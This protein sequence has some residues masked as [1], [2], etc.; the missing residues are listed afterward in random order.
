MG[1]KVFWQ[2]N[3]AVAMGAIDAGARFFSGYPITP[4]SEIAEV[5]SVEL[6]KVG[7]KFMQM[8]DEIA[9]IA[10]AIGASVGGLKAIT[11][12]SGPGFSLKQENLGLACIAEIPIVVV[13]MQRGGPST[14][15][16]TKPLQGD[17]M[18]SRWGTHGDH[19]IIVLSPSSVKECYY[20]TIRAFNLSERFRTPVILLGDEIVAHMREGFELP[21]EGEVEIVNRKH[22]TVPPDEYLPYKADDDDIPPMAAFGEGYR[23]HITG[24]THDETGFPTNDPKKIDELNRRLYRKIYNYLD[25]IVDY[26]EEGIDG[27]KVVLLGYGSVS[28][29]ALSV[30][31]MLR[32]E[33]LPVGYFRPV[34]VWPFPE[35]EVKEISK[36]VDLIVVPEMNMGQL[37]LEVERVSCG[38]AKVLHYGRVD[39]EPISPLELVEFVKGVM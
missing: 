16:P 8:E 39:G 14:G 26:E 33:G 38:G 6:P 30:S 29:S 2:G 18:Q 23:Y 17:V 15:L 22:P 25:E 19:P 1:R 27:A 4:S 13:D 24:L 7:G 32:K 36:K 3:M 37:V 5:L 10:A 12:T 31:R 34:T 21:E 35:R 9:G 28:R 11:A 20:L